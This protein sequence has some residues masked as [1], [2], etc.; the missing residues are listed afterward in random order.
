M[1]ISAELKLIELNDSIRYCDKINQLLDNSINCKKLPS[2]VYTEYNDEKWGPLYKAL[3]ALNCNINEASRIFHGNA[4]GT[5]MIQGKIYYGSQYIIREIYNRITCDYIAK[6]SNRYIVEL[7]AGYGSIIINLMNHC[8]QQGLNNHYYA[9]EYTEYGRKCLSYLTR[10]SPIRIGGCDF[11]S[12]KAPEF[13]RGALVITSMSLMM[14][15]KLRRQ[16]LMEII[17][18]EPSM[19]ICFE[20]IIDFCSNTLLGK[21]Q[22]SYILANEYNTN[23]L[24]L[25][26]ELQNDGHIEICEIVEDFF[27]ENLLLPTSVIRWRPK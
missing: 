8:R 18:R 3:T 6:S 17:K 16:Y 2:S 25:L 20:T 26:R 15:P 22:R 9:Y 21:L 5:C 23:L 12:A 10:E 24:Q 1:E 13:P 4:K 27:A 11:L 19:V 14:V 7:G